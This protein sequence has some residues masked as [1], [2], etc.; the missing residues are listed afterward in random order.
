VRL[1][2][3]GK[4]KYPVTFLGEK[5]SRW[6]SLTTSPPPV[7]RFYRKYGNLDVSKPYGSS[8]LFTGIALPFLPYFYTVLLYTTQMRRD[9][10]LKGFLTSGIN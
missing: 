6:P 4:L 5:G 7:S 3:L 9:K 10:I 2:G 1:E 8:W